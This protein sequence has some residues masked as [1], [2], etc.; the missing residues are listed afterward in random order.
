[1]NTRRQNLATLVLTWLAFA[2]AA[3]GEVPLE[4][5]LVS[6]VQSIQP[7][8]PF[9]VGL[10]LHHG[11]AYHSYWK[12][13]G[14]VGVPTSVQWKL[15]PGFKAGEIEWPEPEPVLMFKIKAQGFERDVVL[16]VKITPPKGLQT[17]GTIRLQGKT[18]WMS[19]ARTCHPGFTDISLDLPV[20]SEE[21]APDEKWHAA[22]EKERGLIPQPCSAWKATAVEMGDSVTL[23]LVPVTSQARTLSAEDVAKIIF[24][25]VDGWIDSD[26]PQLISTEAD[27]KITIKL[28]R[29]EIYLGKEP[30]AT[31]AGLLQL[32]GGWLDDG[33]PATISISPAISR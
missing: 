2:S 26:K 21:P 19:C 27:G 16:P 12:F 18:S 29:S 31:L 9:Y 24:F 20:K 14:I 10:H 28:T 33:R 15:P 8:R 17:G 11:P 6:E 5:T 22:I 4:V 25:T 7:G 23:S 1:M 32:P 13:P 30:P 3:R